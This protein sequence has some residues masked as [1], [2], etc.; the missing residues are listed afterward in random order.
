MHSGSTSR[1]SAATPAGRV[2]A[3]VLALWINLAVQPCAMAMGTD[4]DCPHCPPSAMHDMSMA[5]GHHDMDVEA[6]CATF[7]S[8]CGDV[9][10]FGIDSRGAQAKLKDKAEVPAVS[11]ALP[12]DPISGPAGFST[13]AADPPETAAAPPPTYLLNCVFLD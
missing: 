4:G 9:D 7:G 3:V 8:D 5:H 6:D 10:D 11:C 2:L 1:R 12:P 13:T